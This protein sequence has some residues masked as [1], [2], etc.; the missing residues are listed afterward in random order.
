MHQER[1][2][3]YEL[4]IQLKDVR[5]LCVRNHDT[6]L[7]CID[8]RVYHILVSVYTN[9][10]DKAIDLIYNQANK[11]CCGNS[12]KISCCFESIV[13]TTKPHCFNSQRITRIILRAKFRSPDGQWI[14]IHCKLKRFSIQ[15]RFQHGLCKKLVKYT[16]SRFLYFPQE[17]IY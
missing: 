17:Y 8:W 2:F 13:I 10:F 16:M 1:S 3:S 11:H 6:I 9:P 12:S 14:N 4:F 15:T 7:Y 5:L